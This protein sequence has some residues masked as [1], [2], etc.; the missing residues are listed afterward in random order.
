MKNKTGIYQPI[1]QSYFVERFREMG[2]GDQFSYEGKIALFNY[3]EQLSEDIGE[4]IELD[5]IAL[6]CDY[7]EYKSLDEFNKERFTDES[8]Y[9]ESWDDVANET[10]VIEHSNGAAIIQNY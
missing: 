1:N 10:T 5:V 3:L 9:L 6:C 2:R 4:P 8:D 7:S